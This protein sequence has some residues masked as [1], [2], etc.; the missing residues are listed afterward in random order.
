[1]LLGRDEWG[2]HWISMHRARLAAAE[3]A[4]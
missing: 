4:E 2:A 1:L 3:A